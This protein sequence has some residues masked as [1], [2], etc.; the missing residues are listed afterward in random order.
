[1]EILRPLIKNG[2]KFSLVPAIS[3]TNSITLLS[4]VISD[5]TVIAIY[6]DL[7]R[8]RISC[9]KI[10]FCEHDHDHVWQK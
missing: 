2:T 10:I 7:N 8:Y 5:R 3:N 9:Q 4:I 1:M 6:I